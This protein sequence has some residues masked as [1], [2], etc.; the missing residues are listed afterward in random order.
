DDV[1]HTIVGVLPREAVL[2]DVEAWRP[3]AADFTQGSGWYLSGVGRLKRGVTIQQAND[4]LARVHRGMIA[5]GRK[6]NE[7]TSPAMVPL[8][9]RYLGEL[10]SVTHILL[11]AVAIVLLIACVNI[12]GLMLVRGESRSREIAIRTAVGASRG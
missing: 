4:D 1:P 12:A 2:P 6:V 8:R 10:R 7:I 3:L 9:D 11:S 5:T